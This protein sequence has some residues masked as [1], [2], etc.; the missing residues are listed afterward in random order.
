MRARIVVAAVLL[1]ALAPGS[2]RAQQAPASAPEPDE[3]EV[4]ARQINELKGR[5]AQLESV[6]PGLSKAL[7]DTESQIVAVGGSASAEQRLSAELIVAARRQIIGAYVRGDSSNEP[8]AFAAALS[9]RNSNDAAWSLTLIQVTNRRTVDLM[10]AARLRGTTATR[11]LTDLVGKRDKARDSVTNATHDAAAI[12]S[13]IR[14]TA[15]KLTVVVAA[16]APVTIDGMSTLAYDAYRKAAVSTT[17]ER[18]GCG[19]RWELLAAIGRTESGHGMGRLDA[20]GTAVPAILGPSI[21]ADTDGGTIDTRADHDHAVGPMQ[22]IPSTWR[23]YA[24]DGNNDGKADPNNIY[25]E[26]LAAARYLCVA[27]GSLTLN[28]KEGVAKAILAYNPNQEYLRTVGGRFEALAQ[29][30][31]KGWFSSAEL[32]DVSTDG[33]TGVTGGGTPLGVGSTPLVT[34]NTEVRKLTVFGATTPAVPVMAGEPVA[35]VCNGAST[36]LATRAGL[37][38]CTTTTATLD[39]CV[40][41]P[42]DP[43][44]AACLPDPDKAAQLI[45]SATPLAKADPASAPPYFLVVLQGGDR[46]QPTGGTAAYTCASGAEILGQPNANNTFWLATVRQAGIAARQV[47]VARVVA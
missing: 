3:T 10:R 17:A 11:E 32:P 1:L 22:F 33:A 31:A 29:D 46:C 18:P 34:P 24:A 26:S 15:E 47:P 12:R 42:Y 8:L 5:A 2:A 30:S 38:R 4:L 37:L 44:L 9:Q 45:R 19:L 27:A 14:E 13:Q 39:P 35:A 16:Q 6:I 21:G 20:T 23:R 36:R 43:T 41:A 25:D 40:V 28:T 7:A